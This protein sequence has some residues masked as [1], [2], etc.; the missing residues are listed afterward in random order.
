MESQICTGSGRFAIAP[1]PTSRTTWRAYGSPA[2]KGVVQGG[3]IPYQPWAAA[4]KMENAT[5]RLTA[6]P[7]ANC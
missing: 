5:N 7:L 2:G 1:P 3:P 6:D 4:K